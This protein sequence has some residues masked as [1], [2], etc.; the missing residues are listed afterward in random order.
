MGGPLSEHPWG[1]SPLHERCLSVLPMP[2]FPAHLSSPG[3]L[4]EPPVSSHYGDRQE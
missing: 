3:G 2:W 1:V 4:L